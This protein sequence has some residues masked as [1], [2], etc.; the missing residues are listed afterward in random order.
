MLDDIIM[1]CACPSDLLDAYCQNEMGHIDWKMDFD[2]QGNYIVTFFR[3][4]R[5]ED[6]TREES[7]N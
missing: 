5:T 1:D 2:K 3:H 7:E 4:R 6:D